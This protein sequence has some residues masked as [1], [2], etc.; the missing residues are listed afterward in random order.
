MKMLKILLVI[1]L[2]VSSAS[3]TPYVPP[4]QIETHYGETLFKVPEIDKSYNHFYEFVQI[5]AFEQPLQYEIQNINFGGQREEEIGGMYNIVETDNTLESILVWSRYKELTGNEQYDDEIR[6]A[7]TYAYNFPAWLEGAGYYSSHNCAWALA[8]E[9][10]YRT[11]FNDS[12]HWNYAVQSAN[13]IMNTNLS[14]ASTLNVMVTGW[15]IGNLY[16]YGEATGNQAYMDEA[17]RRGQLIMDW[18]EVS[19]ASRLSSESWAMSSGTFIWGIC[20]SIFRDDPTLGQNW[21][22]TYGPMVQVYEPAIPS[23]SNAWNVAYCN[24]QRGMF[25]VTGD[26]TYIQNHL[27]LT[28]LLLNKDIDNDGGIPASAGGSSNAD[29]SWTTAYLAMFGCDRYI[30][31][32]TDAGVMI[33]REPRDRS[34]LQANVP[35]NIQV[36]IGNWGLAALNDAVVY[37]NGAYQDSLVV[38][39]DPLENMNI[40]F[41]PWT[42]LAAG[43][44]SIWV[45]IEAEGDTNIINDIDVSHFMV[46]AADGLA[47][48]AKSKLV[49]AS[50]VNSSEVNVEFVL[51]TNGFVSLVLYNT[52][53]Q[54]VLDVFDGY[55]TA[56][57]HNFVKNF[58]GSGLSNGI[59]YMRLVSDG[60]SNVKPIMII[61]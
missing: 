45:T 6:D 22:A 58:D 32:Q 8:A 26:S 2:F 51:Q 30:G 44:D 21:L 11:V 14:F 4:E 52:L 56:G 54:K 23:W 49:R 31:A 43:I 60:G 55:L 12:T 15:C 10:K 50:A 41:G 34:R 29:A 35:V 16:L 28:N 59:Y 53:G 61:K 5:A 25:D 46:M 42:P 36:L 47:N 13:Y 48:A 33:I 9:D 38:D 17:V 18:V 24:A 3:A 39:L 27:W 40:N 19:P 57:E 37:V 1:S 7:W 20:N